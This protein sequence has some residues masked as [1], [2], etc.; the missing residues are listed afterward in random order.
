[1]TQA[2]FAATLKAEALT[3][4]EESLP[5]RAFQ[6]AEEVRRLNRG[7][8]AQMRTLLLELR[9]EPLEDVPIGQLL[10]HLVEAA[11]GRSNVQVRLAVHGDEQPSPALNA[12]I[13]RITQEALN[14][15]T[16]HAKASTA[17]VDLDLAQDGVHLIVGDDGCGFDPS[18]HDPT[19][20]GL[21]SMRERAEEAGARFDVVTKLGGG[22]AITVDWETD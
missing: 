15:V 10:R 18:V 12:P 20:M 19:Q 9:G 22:T 7:A 13:Y 3:L 11:E 6:V 17:W 14:N 5:N 16:R 2:L 4:A 1:V 21:R 8:L